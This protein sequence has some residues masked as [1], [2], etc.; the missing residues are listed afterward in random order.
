MSASLKANE[1]S[2]EEILA[3]IR[4]I[5]ADDG[6]APAAE[7][8]T[9]P[10][11]EPAEAGDEDLDVLDLAT[12]APAEP[13]IKPVDLE[14]LPQSV[15]MDEDIEFRVVEEEPAP[16]PSKPAPA[17]ARPA[18]APRQPSP[19]PP[20]A[21]GDD[22]EGLLSPAVGASVAS[23]FQGLSA[24]LVPHNARTLEDLVKEMMRPML[25]S[26][27]DE[28]LPGLVERLVKAEIERLARGS[29]G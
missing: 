2:M 9:P 11:P 13:L 12:V 16:A 19:L 29:R 18:S 10:E 17:Q 6:G 24:M 8:P 7:A 14:P 22:E 5:I 21:Y 26:W 1:P 25:K 4:R 27:L 20:E 28:N 15:D 3:S 23:A